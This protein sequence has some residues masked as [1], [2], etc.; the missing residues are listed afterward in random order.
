MTAL[1][2]FLVQR[3]NAPFREAHEFASRL[4]DYGRREGLS[5]V[6]ID[7]A[8]AS[9]LYAAEQLGTALPLNAEEFAYAR[10][11]VAIVGSRRGRGGPQRAEVERML[12]DAERQLDTRATWLAGRQRAVGTTPVRRRTPPFGSSRPLES[13]HKVC[14]ALSGSGAGSLRPPRPGIREA[15]Q[16]CTPPST[17]SA[18]QG[19]RRVSSG[20]PV[21][22]ATQSSSS[23]VNCSRGM[24]SRS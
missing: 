13:H 6:A 2:E 10:D 22:S 15:A 21:C 11:P 7:Y 12:A 24:P 16:T 23:R 17:R 8:V 3:A 20:T 9:Q 4:T 5:P 1:A 18:S 14:V 19:G